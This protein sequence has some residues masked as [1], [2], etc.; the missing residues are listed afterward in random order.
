MND[1]EQ[2]IEMMFTDGTLDQSVRQEIGPL[3]REGADFYFGERGT[4]DNAETQMIA[5]LIGWGR[6]LHAAGEP[7]ARLVGEGWSNYSAV[8]L[9]SMAMK[10]NRHSPSNN[11]SAIRSNSA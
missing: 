8:P 11:S 3:L 2:L 5:G 10:S 4:Q 1:Y 6:A 9:R 7:R